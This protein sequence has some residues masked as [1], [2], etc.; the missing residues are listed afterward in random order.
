L[1]SAGLLDPARE[2]RDATLS[3]TWLR[4]NIGFWLRGA[5]DG[6]PVPPLR[7][8]R[9]ATGT[10]SLAWSFESG[11]LAAKSIIDALERNRIDI[12]QF[13]SILDFGCAYGRVVRHWVGLSADVHGCDYNP[14]LVRWCRRKLPFASFEVNALQPPL[15]YADAEFDFV[16]ALSVFTH[17]PG[18]L[19]QPWM[20]EMSRVLK[21]GGYLLLTT[22]GEAYFDELTPAEG[23]Q[24]R[25]GLPVVRGEDAAGTNRCG[26]YF[27]EQYIRNGLSHGFRVVDFVPRGA[28]GNPH[29]DLTL[30]Q[31]LPSLEQTAHPSA[32]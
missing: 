26:V 28:I 3:L 31:K 4:S 16:Y 12:R 10:S 7:L 9:L 32:P 5:N 22:H 15:P 11:G 21:P 6:L 25:S 1:S 20:G 24:F 8:V 14:A 27:S 17:L 13:R 30:L 19:L 29:Q 23:Q 18:P 2:L